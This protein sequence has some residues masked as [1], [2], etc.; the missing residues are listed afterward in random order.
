MAIAFT[1]LFVVIHLKAMR[2]EI[3]RRRC[4]ALIAVHVRGGDMAQ[5][6]AGGTAASH[7]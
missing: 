1:L 3:L 7:V 5:G 4:E 6:M 2:A